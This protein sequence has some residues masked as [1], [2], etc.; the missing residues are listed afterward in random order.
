MEGFVGGAMELPT[1]CVAVCVVIFGSGGSCL[2]S[3]FSDTFEFFDLEGK[4][5][6]KHKHEDIEAWER[7]CRK[8]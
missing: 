4:M 5:F 6:R 7:S 8:E 2:C 3:C 1:F